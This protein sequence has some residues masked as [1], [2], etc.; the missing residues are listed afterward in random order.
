MSAHRGRGR[1]YIWVRRRRR[2]KIDKP[3]KAEIHELTQHERWLWTT[4]EEHDVGETEPEAGLGWSNY[5]CRGHSEPRRY[6][7]MVNR[8]VHGIGSASGFECEAQGAR[9]R[10]DSRFPDARPA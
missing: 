9:S 10:D 4:V 5:F 6:R 2:K 1:S 8:H 7:A 3:C